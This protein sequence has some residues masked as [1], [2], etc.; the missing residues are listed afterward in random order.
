MMISTKLSAVA[1][2]NGSFHRW[3]TTT[4]LLLSATMLSSQTTSPTT[5]L[6]KLTAPP[7]HATTISRRKKPR[8]STTAT[9]GTTCSAM[10]ASRSATSRF[11][12]PDARSSGPSL[13]S[14]ESFGLA[15]RKMCATLH[16]WDGFVFHAL[17]IQ[18]TRRRFLPLRFTA[19]ISW[20]CMHA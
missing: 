2:T 5:L 11:R 8:G 4:Q 20:L 16:F 9:A 15:Y 17:E 14:T 10:L 18:A 3:P 12:H 19:G 1:C 7:P 6:C 13:H